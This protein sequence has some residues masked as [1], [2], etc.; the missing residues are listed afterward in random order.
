MFDL[1]FK[2][3]DTNIIWSDDDIDS[4]SKFEWTV[5]IMSS[6]LIEKELQINEWVVML[7]IPTNE[8]KKILTR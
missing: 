3:S 1:H 4:F 7:D 6:Y 5:H 2:I 8:N